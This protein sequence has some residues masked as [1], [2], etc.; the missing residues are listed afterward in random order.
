MDIN[1]VWNLVAIA[2]C[3]MASGFFAGAETAVTGFNPARLY[4]LM[5]EGDKRAKLI[6]TLYKDKEALIGSLLL[7]NSA[8]HILGSGLAAGLAIKLWG[9]GGVF[10]ASAIMTVIVVTFGE[11]LPKTYAILNS[12]SVSLRVSYVLYGICWVLRPF[13]KVVQWIDYPFLRMLGVR[14][15]KGHTA[16]LVSATEAIR[17]TIEMHHHEGDMDREDRDMLGS[18]L[19]LDDRTVSEVMI[20][21]SKV[22]SMDISAD[23][24]AIIS[25]VIASS[26]SRLPLWKDNAENIVGVLHQKDL[27]R[28]LRQQKIGITREMIRRCAQ[29]PW[30]VPESTTLNDQ[31]TAFRSKRKHFACVVD[32]YGAFLGILTLEDIIEEIVGEIDDEHDPLDIAEIIPFGDKAYKV[33][34]TVTIRDLNRH[35]DWDLPDENANTLAGLVL[36]EARVIPDAGAVFE[37]YGY[38]F[39]IE[40]KR[41]NQITQLLIEKLPDAFDDAQE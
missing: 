40:D 11:V 22:E 7:G 39:T 24:E 41:A 35:L 26:H 33:A 1:I 15:G 37:F 13:T 19:D 8:V 21:R 2:I 27:F 34:G 18:I 12:E 32:E 4:S 23:P 30:F 31:L 28:L 16:S 5:Q 3:V 9:E 29:K 10:Y 38:R 14:D 20:H 25:A 6:N 17:G 36:H